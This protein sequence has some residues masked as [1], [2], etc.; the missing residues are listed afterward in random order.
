MAADQF[1]HSIQKDEIHRWQ[2]LFQGLQYRTDLR[3][4]IIG[5][6]LNRIQLID[7]GPHHM[8]FAAFEARLK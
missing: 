2:L 3:L 8:G 6:I 4:H 7:Q 5:L 1:D